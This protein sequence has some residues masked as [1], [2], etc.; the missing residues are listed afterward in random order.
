M[1]GRWRDGSSTESELETG[2]YFYT[3]NV[4]AVEKYLRIKAFETKRRWRHCDSEE[5]D[6]TEQYNIDCFFVLLSQITCTSVV[7]A[8]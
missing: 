2:T 3:Q 1:D 4:V 7:N 8:R 6:F 5:V